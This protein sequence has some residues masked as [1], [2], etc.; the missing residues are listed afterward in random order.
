MI[1]APSILSANFGNLISEIQ[2]I[3]F[4]EADWIHCDIMDGRFVPNLSFGLPVL[5]TIHQH[6]NLPLDV[7]L[8]IVQPGQY[9]EAFR[10]AGA[11]I[12]TV[13]LE[14]CVHL[15][16]TLTEIRDLGMQAGVAVNPSTSLEALRDVLHLVQVVCLMGVNPGFGGQSLIPHTLDRTRR[17]KQMIFETD[18]HAQIEI[19]GGVTLENAPA[20]R[21]AGADILVAGNTVFSSQHP[22]A[23]IRQLKNPT[24]AS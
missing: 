24:Y 13:H 4:S 8:M 7:H 15:H 21:A 22:L 18:T 10:D 5:R 3:N 2:K 1:V 11:S 12:L 16:R 9:L 6:S 17:L 20:L 23:V 14:A 19:D